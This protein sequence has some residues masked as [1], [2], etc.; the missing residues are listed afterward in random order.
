METSDC[1]INFWLLYWCCVHP[2]NAPHNSQERQG[3]QVGKGQGLLPTLRQHPP[4]YAVFGVLGRGGKS[5]PLCR[6]G[7]RNVFSGWVYLVFLA[8]ALMI[9]LEQAFWVGGSS[10]CLW[11]YL[12][13]GRLLPLR[14]GQQRL[15]LFKLKV[16]GE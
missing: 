3:C 13:A 4:Q 2:V 15:V 6:K 7:S 10:S 11:L 9:V 8:T 5:K 12:K 1:E 16:Q 14:D